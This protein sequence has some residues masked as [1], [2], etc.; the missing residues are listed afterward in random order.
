MQVQTKQNGDHMLLIISGN[1]DTKSAQELR[2]E[3]AKA[4]QLK[5]ARVTMDLR[6]VST[7]GSS[8]IGKIL[9][10]FKELRKREAKFEIKGLQENIYK[11]FKAIKLD[12][13]FPISI[14]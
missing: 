2:L 9:L 5:P 12:K 3:L 10:F 7:I 11:V 8:G 1:V 13:L 14:K 6:G 4:L